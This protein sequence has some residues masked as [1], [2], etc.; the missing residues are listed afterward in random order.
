MDSIA[1]IFD[2]HSRRSFEARLSRRFTKRVGTLLV[3]LGWLCV[4]IGIVMLVVLGDSFGWV[5]IFGPSWLFIA[6]IWQRR[7]LAELPVDPVK[8]RI[9]S[10]LSR[11]VLSELPDRPT[12]K[13]IAHAV[14]RSNSGLFFAIR[15]GTTGRLLENI[16][17][18]GQISTD[19][20]WQKACD[21]HRELETKDMHGG[22]LILA[23][24]DLFPPGETVLA[25]LHISRDDIVR[26]IY[27]YEHIADL[28]QKQTILRRTGGV[29]R[30]W[31]FGYIPLL[32]RFGRNLS[33]QIAGGS[34]LTVQLDAHQNAVAQ[35][36]D[37][38]VNGGRQ[39]V[40]LVGGQGS[41]K[42]TIVQAFAS[43]LLD[44][45]SSLPASLKF[46]QVFVLDASAL[47]SAA[48]GRGELEGLIM[49]VLGEAYA[50]KN[51][52]IC[53]D[54]AEMF[55]EEGVGSVDLSNV[56][57]PILEA[58]NLRIILTMD[59]QRL[60]SIGQRNPALVNALNRLMI[61][62]ATKDETIAVM[63]DRLIVTEFQRK[64]TYTYQSL[65][66]VYRLSERYI[67]DVAQPGRAIKLME[68]AASYAEQGL[69]TMN[70]VDRAI[71]E[72]TGVKVAVASQSSEREKLLN[73][74]S[75]IHERMVNQSRAVTIVADAL[76]RARAGVRNEN[77]PIGTFLFLGPTG[78]GKT[79]LSKALADVY[80]GGESQLIRLDLNEFVRPEDVS[81]LIADGAQDSTSLTAQIM[82]Q[83]F[84]VVLLDEIEKASPA[85]LTTLLQL[86][87]E[88][89]LRDIRGR[90]VS[91]R[92][93]IVIATSNAGADRIR[94][95]IE[96]GYQL[97]QFEEQVTNELISSG[98]FRPEFLNRFDEI[99]IFRPFTKDEL[100][101][102]VNLIIAGVNKTLAPQKISVNV[103]ED[104][105]R[106][107]VERGYDPR[108]GARP[109][110]RVVQKSVENTVAKKMLSGELTAGGAI[111]ITYEQVFQSLGDGL[112]QQGS[113]GSGPTGE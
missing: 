33:E 108:L 10:I 29:A 44:A 38:F 82:K 36:I 34:S 19:A 6:T 39:N 68:S 60:L 98:Q 87:D 32:T 54:N 59:E 112:Q 2:P 7:Q 74:E 102:V 65:E 57:L 8:G 88:G 78:V 52:I 11:D 50:A 49:R 28:V 5:A 69:V 42:T 26:G 111:E 95:Y 76:R 72:T 107:L 15:F 101:Q 3:V 67:F 18:D 104:A 96:R 97:E 48:P 105:K 103:N 35:M 94:E 71:E 85:V 1:A 31:S 21:I 47:I 40:A 58:G 53:L 17:D 24:L 13:D 110:R 73:L 92:D 22:I 66:E 109:M 64:V 12:S 83:P 79:E 14:A 20:V 23:L 91:F 113:I 81:R 43:Q 100:V 51:I 41:G 27:W 37:T 46:R 86:L 30:D 80:F 4:T 84:S 75:L 77:R 9:D 16:T 61:K 62:P 90:E 56:L 70:S 25:Q 106:L 55:F 45:S 93:A 89:I 63:Q 99:A